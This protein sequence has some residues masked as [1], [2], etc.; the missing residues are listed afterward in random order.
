[1]SYSDPMLP[2]GDP[3][4]TW[5]LTNRLTEGQVK[6]QDAPGVVAED[7]TDVEVK[8]YGETEQLLNTY[9]IPFDP[10]ATEGEL[11]YPN[12]QELT[13][14]GKS[15]LEFKLTL[16]I[17]TIRDGLR[18]LMPCVRAWYRVDPADFSNAYTINGEIVTIEDEIVTASS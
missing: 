16:H 7:G 4:F 13:D 6:A 14:S 2:E 11:S 5:R 15:R 8:I 18:C 12:A 17:S 9:T 10:V 3:V 1:M